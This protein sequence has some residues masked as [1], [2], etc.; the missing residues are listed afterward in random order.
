MIRYKLGN[1]NQDSTNIVSQ[2][3]I[4]LKKSPD[5]DYLVFELLNCHINIDFV[6]MNL[7]NLIDE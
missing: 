6:T 2:I 3:D 4:Y 1:I 5:K 7:V